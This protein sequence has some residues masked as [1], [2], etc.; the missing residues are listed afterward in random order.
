MSG[1]KEKFPVVL[2]QDLV[3]GDMDAFQHINNTVYFR[4]FEDA[5]IS[6]FEKANLIKYREETQLGPILASTNCNFRVPLAFPDTIQIAASVEK[7]RSK[8]FKMKYVIYSERLDR[9][10]ADGEGLIVFYDYQN[11]QS[12]EIPEPVLAAIHHIQSEKIEKS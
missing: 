11:G 6:Y 9:V 10:A 1:L 3:W 4:Y 7:I 12:C 5:R 2:S 8:T